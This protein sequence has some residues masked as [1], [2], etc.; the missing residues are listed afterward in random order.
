MKIVCELFLFLTE[1]E[2]I[3]KH[4]FRILRGSLSP[5]RASVYVDRIFVRRVHSLKLGIYAKGKL[6]QHVQESYIKRH[7]HRTGLHK[8]YWR[9]MFMNI[10]YIQALRK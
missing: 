5:S 3:G 6:I 8:M 4:V 10:L 9:E 7:S 2:A 1:A